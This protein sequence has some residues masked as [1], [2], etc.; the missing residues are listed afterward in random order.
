MFTSLK[1]TS[2]MYIIWPGVP[3]HLYTTVH[4]YILF[5]SAALSSPKLRP[6]RAGRKIEESGEDEDDNDD[7]DDDDDDED[8]KPEGSENEMETEMLDYM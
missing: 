4:K 7:H 2:I 1:Y 5:L 6:V 3:K 8:Y